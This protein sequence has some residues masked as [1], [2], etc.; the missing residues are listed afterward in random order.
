MSIGTPGIEPD[1]EV[2]SSD[3]IP[4]TADQMGIWWSRVER[5]RTRR[6]VV[7]VEWQTNLDAYEGKPLQHAP[8]ADYVNPNT[9]FADVEQKKAQLFFTTPEVHCIPQEPLSQG[10]ESV[11]LIKQ[12]VLND[13]LGPNGVDAKRMMDKTIFDVLCPAGWGATKIGYDVVTRPVTQ[14]IPHPI[15]GNLP[16]QQSIDVPVYEEFFWEH[17]SPKK[18]LIPDD[19]R[20]NNY[21]KAPWLGMELS[22]PLAVAKRRFKL[23]PDFS[24]TSSEDPYVF[25]DPQ[26]TGSSRPQARDLVTGVE[27]WYHAALEDETVFHPELFRKLVL[28][29]GM[30][31]QPATH[32]DSPYQS[33]DPQGRLTADSMI[34]NPIHV[35]TIRDLTD[36][37]YI[38]SDCS[39]TRDLVDQLSKFLTT[40]V[41]QRDTSIPLRMVDEGVI[42]PDVMKKITDGDYGTFIPVPEGRLEP[43][44]IVEIA[45]AQYPRE[46]YEGQA[47]I[48]RQL[49]KTL[50]LDS[51]QS[52]AT[53]ATNRT[54][55][56]LTIVQNNASVRLKGER[57]RVI[58]F[59]IAGVRK[60]DSLLQ[61]F[62][63]DTNVIQIVGPNGAQGWAQW[64]KQTIAGR[65]AY[66]IKPD[67]GLDLDEATERKNALDVY[68]MIGK[69]P[70][71]DRSYL[72]TEL[73]PA[74]HL[75]PQRLKAQPQPPKPDHPSLSFSFKGE[76]LLN[77]LAVAVMLQGGV[78]VT[79]DMIQQAH[80]LIQTA[81]GI[82]A[83]PVSPSPGVPGMPPPTTPPPGPPGPPPGAGAPPPQPPQPGTM[84]RAPMVTAHEARKTGAISGAPD[85]PQRVGGT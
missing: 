12:A 29:D 68:N 22:M 64:N 46:N 51:N 26:G 38:R 36:S 9:D 69:D 8:T 65:W 24:G 41:K 50:A 14:Q 57:N 18:L 23:P 52:G 70:L 58:Q 63:S 55:T 81:T 62:A 1:R 59:F 16:I 21:D 3:A 7:T 10:Q 73:A 80:T 39:M 60:F 11:I 4:M 85:L 47:R 56:E 44:P 75:D 45:R 76:D 66:A 33:L 28:I 37:A 35:L 17:F 25:E 53:D 54:A 49:A 2:D 42:T 34:G 40:Q 78:T 43:P 30:R 15:P 31:E 82:P 67:S 5:A 27:L 77:P 20:D 84:P 19:Y 32:Q 6:D 61:R 71:V 13:K 74:L 83:P 72:L 79:P 48:E